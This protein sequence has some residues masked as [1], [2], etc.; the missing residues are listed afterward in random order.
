MEN[1]DENL[2]KNVEEYKRVDSN[3]NENQK[4]KSPIAII[5]I[6][7]ILC[8]GG[9]YL[10]SKSQNKETGS[11]TKKEE[12]VEQEK[13]EEKEVEKEQEVK[14][15]K[16]NEYLNNQNSLEVNLFYL[17]EM[18]GEFEEKKLTEDDAK[19]YITS[20]SK[21]PVINYT[22][23]SG[24]GGPDSY[25]AI[26]KYTADKTYEL[27]FGYGTMLSHKK[28]T[29]NKLFELLNK[30]YP[31]KVSMSDYKNTDGDMFEFDDKCTR[32]LIGEYFK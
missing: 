1:K 17:R 16:W 8:I 24:L 22:D 30:E 6:V 11:E 20:L 2:E 4:S 28:I 25:K 14:E 23:V 7:L 15:E 5:L 3:Y 31:E 27:E 12:V 32:N 21:C 9:Y 13:E 29:D 18:G 10:Y 26:I 19:K